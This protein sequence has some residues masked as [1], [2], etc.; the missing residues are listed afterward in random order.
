MLFASLR[1]TY[2]GIKKIDGV[3]LGI[4]GSNLT[5]TNWGANEPSGSGD[6]TYLFP[7]GEW[8]DK[9]CTSV[10]FPYICKKDRK[11]EYIPVI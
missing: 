11:R 7:N 6:C 8:D 3:F 2:I 4:D 1:K 9:S 10:K 5:Y